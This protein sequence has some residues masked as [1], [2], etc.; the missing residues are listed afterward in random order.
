MGQ[1]ISRR[2]V[3][4]L[5]RAM[6]R[7][8]KAMVK[9]ALED[10]AE[11]ERKALSVTRFSD[12]SSLLGG[13]TRGQ[14][15]TNATP[16]MVKKAVDF[17][18]KEAEQEEFIQSKYGDVPKEMPDDLLKFIHD[19]GP[20]QKTVDKSRTSKRILKKAGESNDKSLEEVVDDM[21][22]LE[23]KRRRQLWST[24]TV[25]NTVEI[26]DD[27]AFKNNDSMAIQRERE[28]ETNTTF[29]KEEIL[30]KEEEIIELL[31][32]ILPKQASKSSDTEENLSGGQTNLNKIFK[33]ISNP[34]LMKD[35]D[36]GLVGALPDNVK[37]L[38]M[39]GLKILQQNDAVTINN[40]K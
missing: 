11:K 16:E 37:K 20:A 8:E 6:Q 15:P 19:L 1:Q 23:R 36:E 13:F 2:V 4:I 35:T 12:P 22:K 40:S 38:E 31:K 3:P 27:D 14:I 39:M 28:I 24:H 34:I 7:Q 18:G 25:A 17:Q 9:E 26:A 33:F 21:E 30:Y 5:Q 10:I 32:N 29:D